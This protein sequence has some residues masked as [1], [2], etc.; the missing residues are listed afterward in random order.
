MGPSRIFAILAQNSEPILTSPI[1]N[2]RANLHRR[3]QYTFRALTDK[4][5]AC[6]SLDVTWR[7]VQAMKGEHLMSFEPEQLEFLKRRA[8]DD[9]KRDLADIERLQRRL[10]AF[11]IVAV[12]PVSS[13]VISEPTPDP[14][15]PAAGMF[16]ALLAPSQPEELGNSLRAMFS[17]AS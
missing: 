16:E 12:P 5:A 2:L 15:V 11:S 7:I 13:P 1:G 8:E 4:C 17:S 9:F 3:R 6:H 10:A 14:A